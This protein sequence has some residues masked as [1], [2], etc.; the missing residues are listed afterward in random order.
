MQR[1]LEGRIAVVIG[2]GNPPQ[3]LSNGG[4]AAQCYAREGATVVCVDMDVA[5]AQRTVDSIV[6]AGGKAV[7][8]QA[9]AARQEDIIALRN[10]T[11]ERYG[12]VDILHNNVGTEH[13]CELEDI[14]EEAW[15]RIHDINLKSVLFACQQFIPLMVKQGGGSVVNISSTASIRP[16]PT[17]F[18]LSY[19]TSKAAVNHMTRVLA[20]RYA[21]DQVRVNVIL[22]GMIRTAHATKL[23][24]DPVQ[25]NIERDARCPMGRQGTPEDIGN[26]AAFLAS[27]DARYITG[28]ELRVDGALSL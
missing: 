22:P 23:Y 2:G 28:I 25:A 9:N 16:S 3:G 11:V 21:K 14:T 8:A 17:T 20:R 18:Y 1:N 12:R 7:A 5:A 13:V 6:E 27:D 26:A 24:A 4:A 15:D 10:Q 19:N